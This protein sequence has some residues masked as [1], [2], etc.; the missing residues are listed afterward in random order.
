MGYLNYPSPT[1]IFPALPPITWSVFRKPIMASRVAIATTGRE[2]QVAQAAYPRIAFKVSYGKTS[3]LR[4]RTQNINPWLPLN[5]YTELEAITS[6]YLA[7]GGPYG[8]FYYDDP[9]DNSRTNQYVG[10]ALGYSP[11]TA[12]PPGAN[13]WVFPIPV[14]W[15]TGPFT[16]PMSFPIGGVNVLQQV[17]FDGHPAFS[18][19]VVDST[20]TAIDFSAYSS[21]PS[22][23]ITAD[24][25]FY[26][27]CRFLDDKL[28]FSQWAKN[29]WENAEVNFETVKL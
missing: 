21:P 1:P 10:T 20:N 15:G 26:Y 25:T 7:C 9:D 27:R 29:L 28:S 18:G 19:W 23:R 5:A 8:E 2:T 11:A 6:L 16:P 22:G 4:E 3:W 24:F 17:Y 14:Q 12:P 13:Q